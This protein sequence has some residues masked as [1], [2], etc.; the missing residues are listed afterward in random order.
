MMLRRLSIVLFI[1]VVIASA[2][3]VAQNAPSTRDLERL[4]WMEFKN[5][6]PRRCRPCC[7]RWAR[8]RLTVSRRTAR[9][10]CARRDGRDIAA[11][12]N[13]MVAPV[14]PYGI[15]ASLGAYPGGLTMPEDVYK[16]YDAR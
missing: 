6:C 4:N 9:T 13:A 2:P 8:S 3:T 16:G 7:S 11:R 5:S 14:I 15:T 10:S 1:V 12:V